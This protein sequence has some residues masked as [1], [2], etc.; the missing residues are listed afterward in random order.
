MCHA[1]LFTQSFAAFWPFVLILLDVC[2]SN[3]NILTRELNNKRNLVNEQF[4]NGPRVPG[5]SDAYV[6]GISVCKYVI[7]PLSFGLVPGRK[8]VWLPE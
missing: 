2:V 7:K 8:G 6:V 5:M 4:L 3:T 1:V